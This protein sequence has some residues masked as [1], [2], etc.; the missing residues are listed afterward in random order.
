MLG[1]IKIPSSQES[2]TKF[3]E[4]FH[5]WYT[6][7]FTSLGPFSTQLYFLDDNPF[8]SLHKG[9]EE[10]PFSCQVPH[11]LRIQVPTSLPEH[12]KSAR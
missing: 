7:L 11:P 10:L 2:Q 8:S 9:K 4:G 6:D 5:V 12:L 1:P 3:K